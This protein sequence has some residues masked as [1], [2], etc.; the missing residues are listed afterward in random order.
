MV[1]AGGLVNGNDWVVYMGNTTKTTF[2]T[3][4]D[5]VPLASMT[6]VYSGTLSTA[7]PITPLWMEITLT[8]PFVYNGTDN[9]VIAVDENTP[10]Y[11]SG[12]TWRA[13]ASG[14]NTGI[15]Y[16]NDTNNPDPASPP[17]ASSRSATIA[18]VQLNFLP[19]CTGTP[20]AGTVPASTPACVGSTVNLTATGGT[21]ADGLTYQWLESP[22]GLA[23]WTAVS[24]GSGATTT[25]YT[26]PAFSTTAYYR[27]AITCTPSGL[28]DSTNVATVIDGTTPA[29][30][31]FDGISLVQD[32]EA[33]ANGCS[34]LDKPSA[35]WNNT[36]STGFNSWRR[37]R[38][39]QQ[40]RLDQL[41]GHLFPGFLLGC[42]FGPLPQRGGPEHHHRHHGL[43]RGH[44]RRF[45][46]HE[47]E[48]RLHQ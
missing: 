2:A 15:Y 24:G 41:L 10:S 43:I 32:F 46:H 48:I 12:T 33:W 47:V 4:T 8:T 18:Q 34:T 16:Y 42:P 3:T 40:R 30:A 44:V 35:N 26:T 9:L 6:Q 13:F 31:V 5:W 20:V 21:V 14:T 19:P 36:P 28:S 1:N 25:S 38:S 7:P 45:G 37:D 29:Y 11:T 17:T 23:P 27:M 39:R 22:N